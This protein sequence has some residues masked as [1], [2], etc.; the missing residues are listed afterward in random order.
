MARAD[1]LGATEHGGGACAA[2]VAGSQAGGEGAEAF[3]R[4]EQ[5][6]AKHGKAGVAVKQAETNAHRMLPAGHLIY[7]Y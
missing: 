3:L 4:V 7:R 2:A 1:L 5:L 6:A